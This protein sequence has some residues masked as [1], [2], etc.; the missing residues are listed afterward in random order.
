MIIFLYVSFYLF[1]V[2]AK[3]KTWLTE[4]MPSGSSDLLFKPYINPNHKAVYI[5]GTNESDKPLE[6]TKDRT[7]RNLLLD[8]VGSVYTQ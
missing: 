3:T 7:I 6:V 1:Q 5:R 4:F 8:R 2:K